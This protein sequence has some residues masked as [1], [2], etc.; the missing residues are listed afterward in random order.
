M[1]KKLTIVLSLII[2]ATF[3]MVA[4]AQSNNW[5]KVC[6]SPNTVIQEP[7]TRPNGGAGTLVKCIPENTP[8]PPPPTATI[9]SIT[10]TP[11]DCNPWPSDTPAG[12]LP[13]QLPP[14]F[15]LIENSG[16]GTEQSGLNSWYDNFNHNLSLADFSNTQYREFN[17]IGAWRT[18]YWRHNDHWMVDMAPHP[19]DNN[20]YWDRGMSMLSPDKTFQ[21]ENGKF[22]IETI[23]AAGHSAYS[24]KAWAE[25]VISNGPTPYP[26]PVSLY[27][28]DQ[29]PQHWTLGCRLQASRVP[30]CALKA[31]NGTP[32]QGSQQIWEMAFWL[33]V[34][35]YNFGGYPYGGLEN[36]WHE[37]AITDPDTV[38]LDHF[39]LELT[40]TSLKL[41]VNGGLYFEQSGIPTLPNELLTGAI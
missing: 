8:T 39:R 9:P 29:F 27:A 5:E 35:T 33:P 6:L 20:G 13:S 25:I 30:I 16:S 17:E 14:V 7:Y 41:Y 40:A 26:N 37:C 19:Q 34:G 12:S 24:D 28:Y 1:K 2:L 10:P 31:N 21:F 36:Y 3:T 4:F 22:V 18:I 32:P 15:C 23:V 11:T 38:C